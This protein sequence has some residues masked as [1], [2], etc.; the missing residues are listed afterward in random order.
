MGGFQISGLGTKE[1][2]VPNSWFGSELGT[3]FLFLVPNSD[4]VDVGGLGTKF[5]FL[6]PNRSE[7]SGDGLGTKFLFL[8]PN[9]ELVGGDESEASNHPHTPESNPSY[10]FR[11]KSVHCL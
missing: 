10:S 11:S 8:V 9:S 5:L 2:L 1:L 3:K 6:V 7:L 4:S